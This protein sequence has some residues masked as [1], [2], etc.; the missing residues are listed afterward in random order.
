MLVGPRASAAALSAVTQK[1][2]FV[3]LRWSGRLSLSTGSSPDAFLDAQ[4]S[5]FDQRP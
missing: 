2:E 3:T 5:A 1:N 4:G